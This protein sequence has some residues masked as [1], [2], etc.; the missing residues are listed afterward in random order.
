MPQNASS[1]EILD[2]T[3]DWF[4][5]IPGYFANPYN[6]LRNYNT[7]NLQGDLVAS[8]TVAVVLL[9]QAIAYALI[10][11]LPPQTG[12]FAAIIAATIGALWGS[13]F[14]LHTG[15]TNTN[16]LLVLTGLVAV[17]TPNTPEY[18]A[19]AGVIA[20]WAGVVRLVMGIAKLGVLVNFVSDSV[21]IGFTG[22]AGI[23]IIDKQ[24]AHLF[25]VAG[26]SSPN[27]YVVLTNV[28]SQ[29]RE[30]HL[31]TFYLG[32]AS[33]AALLLIRRFAPKLPGPLITMVV[34]SLTVW[35][36]GLNTQGV[37]VLGEIPRAFPTLA[38]IPLFDF[39]LVSELLPYIIAV[40]LIGLIEA[41]SISRAI[42]SRSGQ[43]LDSDQEFI[44]QGLA[45]IASG[46]FSGYPVAGSLTRSAVNYENGAQTQMAAVFSAG[47]T[48][49]AMLAFAPA[50][51]FLPRVVLSA[52]LIV[53][54]ARM[55]NI[56][57]ARQIFRTS[58]GDTTVM[59]ITFIATL[60][61]ELQFAVLT[62]ILVSLA[63]HII[64]TS[65]PTVEEVLPEDDFRHFSH[66]PDKTG[67]PQ[68]GVLTIM[69]SIYFGAAPFIEDIIRQH[70]RNHPDQPFLLLRFHRVNH[71]DISGIHMLDTVLRLYRENEGDVYLTGVREE[72]ME[73]MQL[74]GFIESIGRENILDQD[75]AIVH[76][77]HNILNPA[78][79]VY[80]CQQKIWR[81]CQSLPKSKIAIQLPKALEPP[82]ITDKSSVT[83]SRFSE[84]L[85]E[86]KPPRIIDIREPEEFSQG[87]L[88]LAESIP[89][90]RFISEKPVDF[91]DNGD[92]V[93]ICRSGRRS[94][95]LTWYLKN[96]GVENVYH[97]DGGMTA[98]EVSSLPKSGL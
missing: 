37:S 21:I 98:L 36:L 51:A 1:Q 29:L 67:C 3:K 38:S 57:G 23:L 69:G 48:L 54:G 5:K 97:L 18:V 77:F 19:A 66:Q 79:C 26:V 52:I 89:M 47:W 4:Q 50:A 92:I 22:G 96:Q 15:P 17:A 10:A 64:Q 12:L 39:A 86:T 91:S 28:L 78:V 30:A 53:T 41:S 83:P 73:F 44:G 76:I 56:V 82:P 25:G 80:S 55:V 62:G 72:V 2:Q 65:M 46:M 45:N 11:Q 6:I 13:S 34:G 90:H 9:P 24:L 49:L 32:L 61:L 87:H 95:Q 43:Y 27:F 84:M 35:W 42:A 20:F 70:Q 63:R 94:N 93:F 40:A 31:P 7:E 60:T 88:R 81:E 58:R 75:R 8:L 59:L 33:I 68:L 74:S 71:M 85:G 16:S 14:H